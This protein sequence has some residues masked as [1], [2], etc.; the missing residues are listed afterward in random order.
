MCHSCVCVCVCAKSPQCQSVFTP[1]V[2]TQ[3]RAVIRAA[4]R[5]S[6]QQCSLIMALADHL[7]LLCVWLS[8]SLVALQ[9]AVEHVGAGKSHLC[10]C[11]GGY[12][13][14]ASWGSHFYCKKTKK[15]NKTELNIVRNADPC[16]PGP[17]G[18]WLPVIF[19]STAP[20]CSTVET[21]LWFCRT[22][23]PWP[24]QMLCCPED[25]FFFFFFLLIE[26][27]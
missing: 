10:V 18:V 4:V 9:V 23:E 13:T 2:E 11:A 27:H 24:L 7:Y 14:F 20:D 16:R 25:V 1:S 21:L 5:G 8:F 17:A 3:H 6:Q 12:C 15:Q 26:G 19:D 22:P